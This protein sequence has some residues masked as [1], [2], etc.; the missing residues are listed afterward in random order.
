VVIELVDEETPLPAIEGLTVTARTGRIASAVV[1]AAAISKLA[2]TA[3]VISVE[4]SRAAGQ[5]ECV[6]SVPYIGAPIVHGQY[7]EIGDMAL[8]ALI[9]T[10]IDVRHAAFRDEGGRS[11]IVAFW[12]QRDPRS[13]AAQPTATISAE[14]R[15]MAE[16]FGL[17]G[18]ALYV[19]EDIEKMIA[20]APAPATFPAALD[21]AHGTFV[22]SIAAGR[23]TGNN[24]NDFP[25]GVAPGAQVVAVRYDL[26]GESVG[27]S[28]G[29]V[30]ALGFIDALARTLDLPVVVNISNGMN[31]GAHDGSSKV[32]VACGE[33]TRQGQKPGRVVVKS[34]GNELNMARHATFTVGQGFT[35]A[36]RWRSTPIPD[37]VNPAS[38]I[39]RI[40]LWFP[41]SNRYKFQVR[42]PQGR[43]CS[44]ISTEF[45]TLDEFLP[46]GNRLG[47]RY[48]LMRS[49]NAQSLLELS[50]TK[51]KSAAVESGEWALLINA[52]ERPT[53]E[54][55]HAWIEV[56][57]NRDIRFLDDP[58]NSC[59][60]TIPG[61]SEHVITVGAVE[62][63]TNPYPFENGSRG[64]TITKLQ[65]PELV[66]PGVQIRA[67]Q[68][69]TVTHVADKAC[70]GTSFS[71]PHV[72][73]VLALVM[74]ARKKKEP[75]GATMFNSI[76]LAA[77]LIDQ[78]KNFT[79]EP[80]SQTGYGSLDA[81]AFFEV[82]DKQD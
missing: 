5:S 50:I 46:N 35:K 3:G 74:S 23:R 11:R 73:G 6:R 72:A 22:A 32:E 76:I 30:Q 65:K 26:D 71:A 68:A 24:A 57:S 21:S 12:D 47:A 4:A 79:H 14:A 1:T 56:I 48:S 37:A 75:G 52:V 38:L 49:E 10:G 62:P 31:S 45:R 18:G 78:L 7:G 60:I 69:G 51:G 54:P 36:L 25:G 61:T 13:S 15:A 33:F 27:N 9:D 39:E 41:R 44:A 66:A 28:N 8:I 2:E 34:A 16:R 58:D 19:R 67:A 77:N 55:I 17:H 80:D 29:H 82:M 64:P 43:R 40:E 59:T 42:T 63:T 70:R 81:V 53:P 20:G